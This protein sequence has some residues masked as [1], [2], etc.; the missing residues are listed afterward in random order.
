MV[1][2]AI[3]HYHIVEKLGDGGM[4]VV[5]KAEDIKLS[6][7]VALKFLPDELARFAN[8]PCLGL[9][10]F[11]LCELRRKTALIRYSLA[12]S[13]LSVLFAIGCGRP[14]L[15]PNKTDVYMYEDTKQLVE[16]VEDAANLIED[17]G[18]AAFK[19]FDR[20]GSRWRTSRTYLF[21][22]DFSG[23][24][25]WH[26]MNPELVGRNLLSFRDALGKPLVQMITDIARRPERDAS[27][28]VFYLWEE[29]TDCLPE[30]KSSY[31]RKAVSPDGKIYFIGSG[32]SRIKVEK[33]FVRE[34]VDAAARLLQERGLEATF[35]ELKN[36]SSPFYFLGTFVF[37]LDAHGR[38]LVDPAYPTLEGRDMSGFRDAIGR[39]VVK[40][41]LQKLEN[42]DS[43]WIQFLWPKPGERLPSR[44][45]MY[46]R[47]VNINGETL[48]V[49][50]DFYLASPIW[51]KF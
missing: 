22:Y 43:A 20:R 48:L 35:H 23:T 37:V 9:L 25:I 8:N 29:Q 21:V 39:P 24:C 47:K 27:G 19:E 26:G 41:L 2:Q 38:S 3:S 1:S 13:V 28:W 40:E 51:M 7:A 42:A 16:F 12:V 10:V 14:T 34:R 45:L 36:T 33:V 31:V 4:G 15:T 17:K 30:W 6:L 49:G 50:S 44:K 32:S 11:D 18:T 5:Y 46:V